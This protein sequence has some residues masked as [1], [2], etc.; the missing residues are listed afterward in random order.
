MTVLSQDDFG[1]TKVWSKPRGDGACT[2][3]PWIGLSIEDLPLD[4]FDLKAEQRAAARS[5][6]EE[7][8]EVRAGSRAGVLRMG[9]LCPTTTEPQKRL[10]KEV[11]RE[12]GSKVHAQMTSGGAERPQGIRQVQQSFHAKEIN[13]LRCFNFA[14]PATAWD[15]PRQ[16]PRQY[17]ELA[18]P[19][20]KGL[21]CT[22]QAPTGVPPPKLCEA[23]KGMNW[24]GWARTGDPG[25]RRQDRP[26]DSIRPKGG[27]DAP[28]EAE[29]RF[30]D[31][32]TKRFPEMTYNE[33]MPLTRWH[34]DAQ[35]PPAGRRV[36]INNIINNAVMTQ[37]AA[38]KG[39]GQVLMPAAG[40]M[41]GLMDGSR[42]QRP[43]SCGPPGLGP[44]KAPL[45]AR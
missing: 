17:E 32:R 21:K 15:D 14:Y 19:G 9:D 26:W 27:G 13:S 6:A 16:W 33:T 35:P 42:Q 44:S 41:S 24:G 31:A 29:L 3:Q 5:Q 7:F 11:Y 4:R 34:L 23:P 45:T 2:P 37:A 8:D 25:R 36:H 10:L 38:K 1:K 12:D 22:T 39:K 30:C 40:K 28:E 18:G 43:A 20:E